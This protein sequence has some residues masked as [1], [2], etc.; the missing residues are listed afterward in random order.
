MYH[1]KMHWLLPE[2]PPPPPRE[3]NQ[4][5]H[6]FLYNNLYVLSSRFSIILYVIHVTN[7]YPYPSEA[8]GN[9]GQ[10]IQSM[11]KIQSHTGIY[12]SELPEWLSHSLHNRVRNR[13]AL[14]TCTNFIHGPSR[15]TNAVLVRRDDPCMKANMKIL[16]V[17]EYTTKQGHVK[18]NSCCMICNRW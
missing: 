15:L 10:A 2:A 17:I 16:P 7:L 11:Y 1:S 12:F 18:T 13:N 6:F 3:V 5:L 9:Q 4:D 14:T 8:S